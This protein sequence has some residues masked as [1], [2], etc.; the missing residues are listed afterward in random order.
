MTCHQHCLPGLGPAADDYSAGVLKWEI[1]ATLHIQRDQGSTLNTN[2]ER[3]N[4]V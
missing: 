4:T 1:G 3:H 2:K